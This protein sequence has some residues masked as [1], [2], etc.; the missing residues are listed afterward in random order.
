MAGVVFLPVL[1]S[2]MSGM[3][4]VLFQKLIQMM[5]E[6]FYRFNITGE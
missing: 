1:L 2:Y 6:A 4:I 3:N 5:L